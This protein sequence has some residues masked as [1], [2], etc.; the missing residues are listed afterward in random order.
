MSRGL[1]PVQKRVLAVVA[2]GIDGEFAA[3]ETSYLK[4]LVGGD[5]SN[6]R[7]AVRELLSRG[8]IE[9]QISDGRRYYGLTL[10]GYIAA[11]P[12]NPTTAPNLLDH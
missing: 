3:L 6:L 12:L 10:F 2:Q 7:R 9:E 5:R 1:G 4:F 11:V 8:M